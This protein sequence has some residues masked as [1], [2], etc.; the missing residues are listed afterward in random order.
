MDR[1]VVKKIVYNYRIIT[2]KLQAELIN[3]CMIQLYKSTLEHEDDEVKEFYDIFEEILEEDGKC[4]TITI[5]MG[6]WN[7]VVGDESYRNF[8][9]PHGL[10]RK[11]HIRLMLINVCERNGL[12]VTNT[13]FRKTVH[14]EGTRRSESTSV[15]LLICETS[16][17]KQCEGFQT[18][19]GADT[20]SDHNVLVAKIWT[21]LRKF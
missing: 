16:I 3:I 21:R 15:S 11:N 19:P 17:E 2:I 13:W 10:G 14:I 1:S 5:T 12:S 18:L 8:V 20:D 9:E 7:N 4:D 6:D